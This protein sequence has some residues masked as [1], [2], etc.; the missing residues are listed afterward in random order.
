MVVAIMRGGG[1]VLKQICSSKYT[2]YMHGFSLLEPR[3]GVVVVAKLMGWNGE[4]TIISCVKAT[5]VPTIP[6]S[7]RGNTITL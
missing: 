1:M 7:V 3:F 6:F 4:A 2:V 5:L